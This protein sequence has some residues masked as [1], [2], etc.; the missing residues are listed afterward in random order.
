MTLDPHVFVLFGGT[1]DL[2]KRLVLPALLD[3]SRA[4]PELDFVVLATA[5][6]E[7]TDAQFRDEVV[8]GMVE[9][10]GVKK[11]EAQ[12]FARK[13]LFFQTLDNDPTPDDYDAI[14][15]KA[16]A[17]AQKYGLG[18]NR[19]YYLAL[20]PGAFE[21]TAGWLGHTGMNKAPEGG[22]VRIVV[23]KPFGHDLASARHLNEVLHRY[24]DEHQ[25]YRI[26]H[27]LAK[28]TVQN[29]LVLR[30][31]NPI[32]ERLWNRDTIERVDI[33]V[34]E[35]V[36]V[37]T[38][39][40]YYDR[41]G[42]VRDMIQNHLTQLYTLMAMELPAGADADA[43]RSEKIKVL[44]STQPIEGRKVVFGQY[45]AGTVDGEDVPAYRDAPKVRS[46][47]DTPTFAAIVLH[48][49]NWR[50][51]G[52]PFVL[53]TG[54]ALKGRVSEIVVTFR[55]APISFFRDMKGCDVPPNQLRIELQPDEA[56]SLSFGVKRPGDGMVVE[57]ERFTFDYNDAFGEPAPAYRTLVEDIIRGDQTLFV[58]ADE[59][60]A[61]WRLYDPVLR[62]DRT[63][64]PYPAGS[65]GP[66]QAAKITDLT[67][68]PAEE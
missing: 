24:F 34:A 48:V 37:G 68:L 5:R 1:G 19:V 56:F 46:G 7:L 42:V 17:L 47:S 65:W 58:H 45:T 10:G 13:R 64:Y 54:K 30:M 23:E 32:F 28:E 27:Y 41:A 8:R 16:D 55:S 51:E 67:G 63:V 18:Q 4:N 29:L 12:R 44:R 21:M 53:S 15:D 39:G 61:S 9:V 11:G 25:V 31:A 57:P 2:S 52:V 60:E 3:L 49:G 66:E 59:V 36:G 50:W 62:R 6:A 40:G 38:R 26:D 22:W 43:I 35:T 33:R 14:R 20:P